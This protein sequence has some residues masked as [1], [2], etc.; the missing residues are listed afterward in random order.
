[1]ALESM[2]LPT[3]AGLAPRRERPFG[4][5][6]SLEVRLASSTEEVRA[7]QALRYRVFYGE[8]GARATPLQRFTGRDEDRFDAHCDHLLVVD[9]EGGEE[10][11][12][13]SY[14]L[15][16]A[17]RA[18]AAGGF[19]SSPEFAV[20]ELVARHARRRFLE[21]GRS[22]VLKPW[23]G[24]R[25]VE[26]LWQGIWCYVLE[27][28]IDVLFGCASLPGT[29]AQA[30]APA[31]SFLQQAAPAPAQWQVRA[32]S[33]DIVAEGESLAAGRS[34]L[35]TLP[36]LLKGYLKLGALISTDAVIDRQFGTTDVFVVLPVERIAARYLAYYGPDSARFGL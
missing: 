27:R 7:A 20:E 24:K 13:G 4:R 17:E 15:M 30:T 10:R 3:P 23:R 28:G 31:L 35:Q 26:L 14:R 33:R 21:L 29:D 1:M 18:G 5:L 36:P 32:S 9:R 16:P 25:T 22:C 19:Y 34:A 8:M 11:I 2:S 6:G 12:V